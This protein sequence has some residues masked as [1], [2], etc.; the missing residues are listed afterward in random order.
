MTNDP[1]PLDSVND[2]ADSATVS[3]DNSNML[4]D[5]MLGASAAF[6]INGTVESS[7]PL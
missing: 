6:T 7:A 2:K 4:S 3:V 1:L 5:V